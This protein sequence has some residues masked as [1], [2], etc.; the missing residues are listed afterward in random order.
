ML[1]QKLHIWQFEQFEQCNLHTETFTMQ[2]AQNHIPKAT[3]LKQFPQNNLYKAQTKTSCAKH[4]L[5]IKL[6]TEM[7]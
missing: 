6:H 7:L 4:T 1:L 3:A 2:Y 5:Q